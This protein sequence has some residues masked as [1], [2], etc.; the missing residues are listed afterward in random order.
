MESETIK[1]EMSKKEIEV[2]ADLLL[3]A[4]VDGMVEKEYKIVNEL[5][6]KLLKVI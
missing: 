4:L 1:V 3:G 2:L 6:E 5:Y